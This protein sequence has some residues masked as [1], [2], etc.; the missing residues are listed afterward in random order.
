MAG[1]E[2]E[3]HNIESLSSKQKMGLSNDLN[4]SHNDISKS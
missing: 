1:G 4:L 3:R 2:G